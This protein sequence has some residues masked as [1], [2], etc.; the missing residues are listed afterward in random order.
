MEKMATLY[1]KYRSFGVVRAAVAILPV[2][3]FGL[4]LLGVYRPNPDCN[5]SCGLI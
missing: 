2:A 4:G 5:T 1:L 3:L